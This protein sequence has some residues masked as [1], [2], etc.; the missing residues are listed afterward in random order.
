VFVEYSVD[1]AA[2]FIQAAA[3]PGDVIATSQLTLLCAAI[4][5]ARSRT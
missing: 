1:A 3:E 4:S 2:G 5:S